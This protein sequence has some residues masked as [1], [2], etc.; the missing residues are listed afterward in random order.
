MRLSDQPRGFKR[1]PR[2]ALAVLFLLASPVAADTTYYHHVFFDN[3]LN[4]DSYFYSSAKVSAPSELLITNGKLPIESKIFKTPPNALHLEWKSAAQ[5]GW[6][7]GIDVMRFRNR[8]FRFDGDT[9]SFLV[10]LEGR[11]SRK[12]PTSFANRRHRQRILH[13]A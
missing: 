7:A 10:L 11:N 1:A 2:L 13:R 9:L 8:E 4:R 5:G 12:S 3:S 6:D